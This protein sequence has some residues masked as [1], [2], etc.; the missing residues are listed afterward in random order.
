MSSRWPAALAALTLA[1][2]GAAD[3][4]EPVPTAGPDSRG[5]PAILTEPRQDGEILVSAEASPQSHGPYRFDGRYRAQFAQFAPEDPDLDFTH[6][7]PFVVE[8]GPERPG[9]RAKWIKLF[10]KAAATGAKTVEIHGRHTVDVNFG[11]FPYAVR[12]T[13]VSR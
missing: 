10:R 13:P 1:G 12:F 9:P 6:E 8:L 4:P 7:A 11:D 5:A 3:P 2:C